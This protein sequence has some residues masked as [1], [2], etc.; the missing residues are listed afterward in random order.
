MFPETVTERMIYINQIE[1]AKRLVQILKIDHKCDMITRQ[2]HLAREVPEIDIILGGHDHVYHVEL[3][4]DVLFLISGTDFEEFS[5]IKI[6]FNMNQ[7]SADSFLKNHPETDHYK[8]LNSKS[9]RMIFEVTKVVIDNTYEPNP[10]VQAH[11]LKYTGKLN[12]D[13]DEVRIY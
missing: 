1:T 9:K 11:V 12:Q 13:L 5:N 6:N 10:G 2:R 8:V 4:N 3:V 7:E